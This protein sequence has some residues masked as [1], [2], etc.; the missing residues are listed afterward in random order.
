[1]TG[2]TKTEVCDKLNKLQAGGHAL[3]SAL[4]PVELPE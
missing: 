2:R 4:L 1:V 3:T